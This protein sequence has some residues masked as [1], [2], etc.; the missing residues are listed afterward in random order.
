MQ[1]GIG[2][3]AR[4][5]AQIRMDDGVRRIGDAVLGERAHARGVEKRRD[6]VIGAF[7]QADHLAR[8][9]GGEDEF[10]FGIARLRDIDGNREFRR[11][12]RFV[13]EH[14]DDPQGAGIENQAFARR[15]AVH[16]HFFGH[17]GEAEIGVDDIGAGGE[18]ERRGGVGR[19]GDELM[20]AVGERGLVIDAPGEPPAQGLRV[21]RAQ[22]GR[23]QQHRL[24]LVGRGVELLRGCKTGGQRDRGLRRQQGLLGG[25]RAG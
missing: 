10:G 15:L 20:G 16:D 19:F 18:G 2:E 12:D 5:D 4:L 14:G 9:G 3:L 8:F 6:D 22:K 23:K 21:R 1:R 11:I 24:G 25:G 13:A 17:A 7:R